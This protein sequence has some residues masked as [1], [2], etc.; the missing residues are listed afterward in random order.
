MIDVW[1]LATKEFEI[2]K[3][4]D[5]ARKLLALPPIA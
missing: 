5:L 1:F 4:R 3:H 2:D